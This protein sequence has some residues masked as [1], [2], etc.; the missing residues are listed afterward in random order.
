MDKCKIKAIQ[1]DL[2]IFKT[3]CNSGIYK[4]VVYAEPWHIQNQ[5][6]IQNPAIFTSLVYSEHRYIHN[7]G[8]FKI[9]GIFRTLSNMYD[10]AFCE[11][12]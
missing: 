4:T 7:A 8:I 1:T 9:R 12:S 5:K 11:N 2:G 3:L 10:E 6:Y